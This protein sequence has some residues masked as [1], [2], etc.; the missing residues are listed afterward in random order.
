MIEIDSL[1]TGFSLWLMLMK[2][3][4]EGVFWAAACKLQR[5]KLKI[6]IDWDEWLSFS[7]F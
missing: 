1:K 4:S 6:V 2:E 3:R 7:N 5:T